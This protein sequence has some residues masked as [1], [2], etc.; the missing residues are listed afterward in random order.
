M[1]KRTDYSVDEWEA[2][3]RAPAEAVVAIEQASPSGFFGRRKEAKAGRR[4][5]TDVIG[6]FGDL[7]LVADL[8]AVRE[9]EGQVIDGL[10]AGGEPMIDQAI[11]TATAARVALKARATREEQEAYA[12]GVLRLAESVALAAREGEMNEVSAAETLLLRRLADALGRRD[13]E[14]PGERWVRDM[15]APPGV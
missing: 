12:N 10:R 4:S 13:Y 3:R 14:P 2:I 7:E 8:V 9:A 5:L 11:A 15:G 1:S 6:Q